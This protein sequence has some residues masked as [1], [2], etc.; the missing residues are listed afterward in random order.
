MLPPLRAWLKLWPT[1]QNHTRPMLIYRVT[2]NELQIII[3]FMMILLML[4]YII[5]ELLSHTKVPEDDVEQILNCHTPRNVPEGHDA[6]SQF[7]C[8]QN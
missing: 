2:S 1:H 4:K 8:S 3:S 7:F 6:L 5:T